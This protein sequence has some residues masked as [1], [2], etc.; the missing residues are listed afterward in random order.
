MA[1]NTKKTD[2]R[3]KRKKTSQGK[4]RKVIMSK[5]STPAFAVHVE[6]SE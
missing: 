3:R 2:A 4:K 5:M 6:K 1:S